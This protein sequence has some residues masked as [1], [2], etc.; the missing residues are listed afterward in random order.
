M[1]SSR[2]KLQLKHPGSGCRCASAMSTER[3]LIRRAE[4]TLMRARLQEILQ[5]EGYKGCDPTIAPRPVRL[6]P[7]YRPLEAIAGAEVCPEAAEPFVE[8]DPLSGQL[9]RFRIWIS[10]QQEVTW[11]RA[12]MAIRQLQILDWRAAFEICGNSEEVVFHV[13]C[14]R[15]DAPRLRAAIEGAFEC[16]RVTP[17][18]DPVRS[19]LA[20]LHDSPKFY[21]FYVPPP[22]WHR[23]T[24]SEELHLSPLATIIHELSRITPPALGLYQVLFQPV[25]G[26]HDWHQHI[27]AL[28]DLEYMAHLAPGGAGQRNPQQTPSGDLRHS[29][30]DVASKADDNL[31]LFACAA[32][33][34]I[35]GNQPDADRRLAAMA[36]FSGVIQH[37]GRPLS[38]LRETEYAAHFGASEVGRLLSEGLT[39]RHGFLLNAAELAT[40]VHIPKGEVNDPHRLN[41]HRSSNMT[42]LEPLP[43]G[44][45]VAQGSFLGESRYAGQSQRV[46]LPPELRLEHTHLMGE[47]GTGKSCALQ[48]VILDDIARGDGVAVIDPHAD[49]VESLLDRIPEEA[50]DRVVY[51]SWQDPDHVPVWNPLLENQI[52]HA[53]LVADVIAAL[54]TFLEGWGDRLEHLIRMTVLGL[55]Q[56]QKPTLVDVA[57]VLRPKTDRSKQLREQVLQHVTNPRVRAFF[58]DELPRYGVSELQP[59]RHKLSKLTAE[60]PLSDTLSCPDTAFTLRRIMDEQAILLV[61]LS[62]LGGELQSIAG[63]LILSLVNAAAVSRSDIPHE[64]RRLF[65]LHVDEA[66]RFAP[67]SLESIIAETRKYGVSLTLAHQRFAQLS[68]RQAKALR[69]VG[70]TVAFRVSTDDAEQLCRGFQKRVIPEDLIRLGRGEAIVNIGSH[71]ARVHTA[72]PTEA[73]APGCRRKILERSRQRYYRTRHDGGFTSQRKSAVER[74]DTVTSQAAEAETFSFD[75]F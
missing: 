36:A 48:R 73:L 63:S 53:R 7:P 44:P 50:A 14:C 68:S 16:C 15:E 26:D 75:E 55:L 21:D 39:Y 22:Y 56:T 61:D 2:V 34:A 11:E 72:G 47:S 42:P 8:T 57:D 9:E 3:A 6:E 30:E 74:T 27:R 38:Y 54:R 43:A 31:P 59:P 1:P 49:L 18:E 28:T 66:Q 65:H 70:S 46:C 37:Q 41:I 69:G 29:A 4:P 23:V 17:T 71:I 52:S 24:S 5:A 60:G 10:P 62:G 40:F 12:R 20:R 35:T 58:E 13:G 25:A 32:R 51:L 67:D 45:A 33:L 19:S 64:Q